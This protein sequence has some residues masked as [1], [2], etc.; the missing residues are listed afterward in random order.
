MYG[1]TSQRQ[2]R[3]WTTIVA[4]VAS[5]ALLLSACSGGSDDDTTSEDGDGEATS[6]AP[7]AAGEYDEDAIIEAGIS[8]SLGGSF[9]PVLASGAVTVSANGHIFEGLTELDPVTR[10]VFPALGTDLP[11][12]IDETTYE[13]DLREGRLPQ[14]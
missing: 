8:Y 7:P 6:A 10:E 3:R 12:Q 4:G 1:T 9:D 11:R 14:R 13:V 5:A 2:T